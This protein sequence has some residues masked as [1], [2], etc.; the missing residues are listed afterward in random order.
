MYTVSGIVTLCKLPYRA[1]IESGLSINATGVHDTKPQDIRTYP[2]Y[3]YILK[4]Q[5]EVW[6]LPDAPATQPDI[7]ATCVHNTVTQNFIFSFSTPVLDHS[8]SAMY[9]H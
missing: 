1:L 5:I 4:H 8:I 7:H 2:F 6:R 3:S 9:Y